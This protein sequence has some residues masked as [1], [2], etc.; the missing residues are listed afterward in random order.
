MRSLTGDVLHQVSDHFRRIMVFDRS[1]DIVVHAEPAKLGDLRVSS[2]SGLDEGRDHFGRRGLAQT[3]GDGPVDVRSALQD[4]DV[5]ELVRRRRSVCFYFGQ[6]SLRDLLRRYAA[7]VLAA[8]VLQS[9]QHFFRRPVPPD[10][11][12]AVEICFARA[13]VD[14]GGRA[15]QVVEE[16]PRRLGN[17]ER[18]SNFLNLRSQQRRGLRGD[19]VDHGIPV[20]GQRLPGSRQGRDVSDGTRVIGG[21]VPSGRS[22]G[23]TGSPYGDAVMIAFR[24][25]S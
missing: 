11:E 2:W 1:Q 10:V 8:L 19:V 3:V 20:E 6:E 14:V 9:G 16:V 7:E 5:V 24:L 12:E 15:T 25:G 4:F 23:T 22:G 17:D 18:W 21:C 13:G